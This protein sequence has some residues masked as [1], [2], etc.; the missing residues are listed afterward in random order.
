VE[1]VRRGIA[2]V[3][4]ASPRLELRVATVGAFPADRHARVLWAGLDDPEGG[5][6]AIAAGLGASLAGSVKP[7]ERG[8]SAHLTV[9][10]LREPENVTDALAGLGGVSSDP[11]PVDRLVLYRSHLR[12]AAPLYEPV[13]TFPLEEAEPPGR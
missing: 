10:R 9:A 3:A 2:E 6:A 11:F 5:L 1:D 7:E 8:F 12:R 13:E 4:N